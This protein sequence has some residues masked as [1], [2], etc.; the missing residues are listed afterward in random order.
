LCE[1]LMAGENSQMCSG[2]GPVLIQSQN[3]GEPNGPVLAE[4]SEGSVWVCVCVC[5]RWCVCVCVFWC[6]CV[7]AGVCAVCVSLCV[8]LWVCVCVCVCVWLCVCV[9]ERESKRERD[10]TLCGAD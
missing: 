5:V 9:C 4:Q 2:S 3:R 6:V 8:L 1:T 10:H 7:C